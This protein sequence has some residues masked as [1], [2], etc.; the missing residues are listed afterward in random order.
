MSSLLSRRTILR[1]AGAAA[2]LGASA[3]VLPMFSTPSRKQTPQSCPSLDHSDTEHELIV[4]N[5]PA[6]MDPIDEP[7]S[8]VSG[9]ERS[10]GITVHYTEDVSDNL[11]FY[12]KVV[13][14]L[15]SCETVKRDLFVLTDWMVTQ[16]LNLGWIQELD[17]SRM[18]NVD[19]NLLPK[20]KQVAFDPGRKYSVPWQTGFTGIAYN[21]ALVP[22]VRSY[23][24]LLNR[25]DL[26]GR[27][28]LLNEMQD[29]MCAMLRRNGADPM[30][31]DHD[32]WQA[33]LEVLKQARRRGQ[34]RAFTGNEY[35][36]DLAAGNI[37]ACLAWS[38]DTIQ[39]QFENPD[40]R[41]VVPEEGLYFFSDNML[42]PNLATHKANAEQ[43]INYY[44]DPE[45]AARLA[46]YV[47]FVC[48]VAGAQAAMERIAPELVDNPLIF[49]TGEFLAN[50][51]E[52]MPLGETLNKRYRRDFADAIGG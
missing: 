48:P 8:T 51:F 41:F 11:S 40:I 3:G 9:F 29:T 19:A 52:F 16:M 2:F 12:A 13:N 21:A 31:F 1:A 50:S 15:G 49:P 25:E 46:A 5:W 10:T 39:L 20:L 35:L 32:D 36:R 44:Y 4:S 26:R 43:W 18:P 42:V 27:V 34:I 47:N 23:A 28:T 7:E 22:E 37:V 33:A 30:K 17:H 38:G 6:Y 24:G 14:Q 45:V